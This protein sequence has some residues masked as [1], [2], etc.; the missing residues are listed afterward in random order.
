MLFLL[1]FQFFSP[2]FSL[3]IFW[4]IIVSVIGYALTL[5]HIFTFQRQQPGTQHITP[6][7]LILLGLLIQSRP[8]LF[9]C[10]IQTQIN[11]SKKTRESQMRH[12]SRHQLRRTGAVVKFKN[13]YN[14]HVD[15]CT[16][17]YFISHPRLNFQV[18]NPEFIDIQKLRVCQLSIHSDNSFLF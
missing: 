11:K 2:G 6:V 14:E 13:N 7:V 3:Y 12:W 17:T 9:S 5:W 16:P 8:L 4:E 1:L 10:S 18:L 15:P